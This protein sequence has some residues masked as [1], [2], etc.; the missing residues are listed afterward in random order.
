M[1][2]PSESKSQYGIGSPLP[3]DRHRRVCAASALESVP[4]GRLQQELLHFKLRLDGLRK[5]Y[6]AAGRDHTSCGLADASV[7][8]SAGWLCGSS[9]SICIGPTPWR[10]DSLQVVDIDLHRLAQ[11]RVLYLH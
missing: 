8:V 6:G 3:S 2:G 10:R 1:L 11:Y 4:L 5:A 9:A 7:S